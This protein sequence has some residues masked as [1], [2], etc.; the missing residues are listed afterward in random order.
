[1]KKRIALMMAL[2]M[3]LTL[4]AAALANEN[5][6]LELV[7]EDCDRLLFSLDN[8]TLK[9]GVELSLDGEWFKT[10]DGVYMQDGYRSYWDLKVR[11]PRRFKAGEIKESGYTV[12]GDRETVFVTEVIFPGV[13]KSGCTDAR[14]TVLRNT[15]QTTLLMELFR[16]LA[17]QASSLLDE[18]SLTLTANEKGGREI[19]VKLDN[20][21]PE[22]VDLALTML[23]RFAG[24]R[25]FRLDGDD[26]DIELTGTFAE[27]QTVSQAI[28][29]STSSVNLKNMEMVLK[30]NE[31]GELESVEGQ[32]AVKLNTT[33]D[34]ERL[35][36]GR[37]HLEVSDRGNTM[38]K[39]FD[40]SGLAPAAF[41]DYESDDD[42]MTA[43]MLESPDSIFPTLGTGA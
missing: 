37:F 4:A 19:R 3:V 42:G 38:V 41:P 16:S 24:K 12:Y 32:A 20:G 26:V 30:M 8:V 43:P 9:G 15:L 31:K 14:N 2:M 35:L 17:G 25:Y 34:G 10:A 22:L 7:A 18:Q 11:S 39:K 28:V 40:P 6:A 23:L 29:G 1:M 27:Y 13:Y 5:N 36:E 21:A 33:R